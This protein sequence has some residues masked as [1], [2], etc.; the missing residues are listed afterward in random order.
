MD[1]LIEDRRTSGNQQEHP[2]RSQ[3]E[4]SR[5]LS[6]DGVSVTSVLSYKSSLSSPA[7]YSEWGSVCKTEEKRTD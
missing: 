2:S 1:F 6:F 4:I 3:R 7:Q 5:V